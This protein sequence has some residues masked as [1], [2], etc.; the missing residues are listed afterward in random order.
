MRLF[1]SIDDFKNSLG[2]INKFKKVLNVLE[3]KIILRIM[4]IIMLMVF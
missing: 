4:C 2:H 1:D 3:E